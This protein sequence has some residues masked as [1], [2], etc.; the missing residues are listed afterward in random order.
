MAARSPLT[1]VSIIAPSDF[2]TTA[3]AVATAF[4]GTSNRMALIGWC[5]GRA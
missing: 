1:S 4:V 5:E 2:A 3:D